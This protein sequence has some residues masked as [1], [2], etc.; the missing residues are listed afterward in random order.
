M[1][2]GGADM[3]HEGRHLVKG[4]LLAG[5]YG[6]RLYP[7]TINTSKQL[8][9]VY[10]KPMIYYSLSLLMLAGIREILL[11]CAPEA[12]PQFKTLLRDGS[13]WG[14]RLEYAEQDKPRGIAHALIL[15]EDFIGDHPVS[16]M[17]G[18]NI[19]FGH[20]LPNQLEDAMRLTEGAVIFAYRVKDPQRYGIVEFDA[21]G[22]A[23]SIEEKPSKPRSNF[24]VPGIY[25]YDHRAVTIAR[26]LAPSPR[27]ELEITDLNRVYLEEGTLKV[28][29]I[30]RGIAWFDAGTHTSLLQASNFVQTL[31]ERQGLQVACLE[32]IAYRRGYI[33][34]E[35][36]KA[37]IPA[38]KGN[39][40]CDYLTELANSVI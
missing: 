26:N 16:L 4:I 31:Q 12:L 27:G 34:R 9:P 17:L 40:Y 32:E 14:I 19:F 35:Q 30:G 18:D 29:E 13:Q 33:T 6:T 24:A 8:L 15:A 22:K 11:I 37:L 10:D 25:F 1:L 20:D 5:G 23:I 36:L 28:S 2:F 38:V 21:S 3:A 7:L 39:D